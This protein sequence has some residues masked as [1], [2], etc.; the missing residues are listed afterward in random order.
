M[1][2]SF[3]QKYFASSWIMVMSVPK[4]YFFFTCRSD[5]ANRTHRQTDRQMYLCF[6][7]SYS[8]TWLHIALNNATRTIISH[9]LFFV[10]YI[11]LIIVSEWLKHCWAIRSVTFTRWVPFLGLLKI[12]SLVFQVPDCSS[13]IKE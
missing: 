9:E 7:H 8:L 1:I 10:K 2:F 5:K 3:T 13:G 11:T 12:P 6:Y 4:A